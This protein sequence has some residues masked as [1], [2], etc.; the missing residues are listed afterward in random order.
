MK[1]MRRFRDA[2][3]APLL[4][5]VKTSVAAVLAWL[6]AGLILP[7]ELPIFAAIASLLVVQPSVNQSFGK[8]I[9][10]SV[11]VI[12]GVVIATLLSLLLGQYTWVVML[13]I[14][15]AVLL[16]WALRMTTGTA[17]QVAISAMLVLAL[18]ASSPEYALDRI[19][20][21]LIGAALGFIVNVVI[22]PPVLISPVRENVILLGNEL[23]S[24]LQRL[25]RALS[26]PQSTGDRERLMIEA[27]L[28]RPMKDAAVTAIE[29]GEDSLS[30]NPRKSAHRDQLRELHD[31]TDR[32]GPVVTRVIGMT[33]A[34]RDH[35]DEALYQ[36]PTLNAIADQLNRAAH[37]L[38]LIMRPSDPDPEP[39]TS[40]FPALTA[41]LQVTAPRSMHWVL[42][43]SLME[44]LRRI[45]EELLIQTEDD[46]D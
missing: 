4:Q 14:I 44:D 35:Y 43:G 30:L 20:E 27:R 15:V 10:R 29:A 34:F 23:A 7:V 33:R 25:A 28:L 45:R 19:V 32:F 46:V 39:M 1:L 36:E 16:S 12:A 40:E 26:E 9:E 38:R 5:V 22:V 18:G 37:D 21:T 3:R 6:V 24:T 8:A 41:P 2:K 17:N 42:I 11:G 31:V 13:A